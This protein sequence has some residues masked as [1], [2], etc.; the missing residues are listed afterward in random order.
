L[1]PFIASV[2]NVK[3][4]RDQDTEFGEV[5]YALICADIG[6]NTVPSEQ[7]DKTKLSQL[8][9]SQQAA[10]LC[11]LDEFLDVF[12]DHP[13]LCTVIEHEIHV[14]PDFKPRMTKAYRVPETLKIEIERQVDELLKLGFIVPSKRLAESYVF[15]N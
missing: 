5:E 14:T 12:A 11:V 2:Q 1:R 7:I 10:L 4:I 15:L 3:I 9:P 13:G 8:D 6:P